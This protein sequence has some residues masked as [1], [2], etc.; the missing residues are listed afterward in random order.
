MQFKKLSASYILKVDELFEGKG[1]EVEPE[2]KMKTSLYNKYIDRLTRIPDSTRPLFLELSDRFDRIGITEIYKLFSEA[3]DK[4]DKAYLTNAKKIYIIPLVELEIRPKQEYRGENVLKKLW[5]YLKFIFKKPKA[6]RPKNKSGERV[7]SIVEIEYRDLEHSDK[8]IFPENYARFKSIFNSKKDLLI[9]VDDFIGSGDTAN[10]ILSQY[11]K[12]KKFNSKNT[13]LISLIS[14]KIGVEAIRKKHKVN[15][16]QSILRERCISDYYP[17]ALANENIKK[18]EM[19][20]ESIKC[21]TDLSLGYKKSEA[22]VS[23]MN[24][25]PN[26]TLPIFWHETR[27]LAAPF[28]R[29]KAYNK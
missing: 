25:S 7:L 10:N 27:S 19:M 26:N 14:Q 24:K 18:V 20:E 13:I 21:V 12:T 4:V 23:I 16:F 28:P 15:V 17:I 3:Y 8:F 11:F 2:K 5:S 9:L 1:W 6:V 29:R 22:L